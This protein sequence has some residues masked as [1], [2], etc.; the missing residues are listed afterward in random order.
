MTLRFTRGVTNI[1][2]FCVE[3]D[4]FWGG[5]GAIAPKHTDWNQSNNNPGQISQLKI[6]VG[7][8]ASC[9][10]DFLG[11]LFGKHHVTDN[12]IALVLT[13]IIKMFFPKACFK[14]STLPF[15]MRTLKSRERRKKI[16]VF[17]VASYKRIWFCE[18]CL[19]RP[20]LE[21]LLKQTHSLTSFF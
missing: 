6:K 14:V 3:W 11:A 5:H 13:C 21:I 7:V 15:K 19:K 4:C 17:F 2:C 9:S 20:G 1:W 8:I 16:I 10:Q 12:F 18:S